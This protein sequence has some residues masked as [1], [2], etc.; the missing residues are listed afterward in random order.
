MFKKYLYS[1]CFF[2]GT[3]CL[4]FSFSYK[5]DD[6]G[7]LAFPIK[8]THYFSSLYGYRDLGG[9]H[10]H[11]GVDVPLSPGTPIYALN[12]GTVSYEGFLSSYGN[13][14]IISY[15]NG[16]KSIYGHTS[17]TYPF[18]VGEEVTSSDIVTYVG[19]KY[20]DSGNLNGFTTGP[21]LH[22]ALYCNGNNI[23]PLS[24]KYM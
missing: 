3:M 22:F 21:H 11:N 23:D 12:S 2:L 14:L 1:F 6:L 17:G 13:C 24:V 8:Q 9:Y 7:L 5:S 10:F 15:Y 20:L 19:P 18:K 16:Y 4:F